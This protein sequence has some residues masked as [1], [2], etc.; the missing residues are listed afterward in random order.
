MAP[1]WPLAA[2]LLCAVPLA[3]QQENR[4][5]D[6]TTREDMEWANLWW[7]HA[8]DTKL[9]RVLLIGDSITNGY[10][11]KVRDLLRGRAN[12]DLL[13][14]SAS[15]C[16]PALIAQVKLAVGD[17]KHAIIHFNNGLHGFH[18]DEA[19]YEAGLRRL[20]DTLKQLE[21]QAKLIWAMSTPI[22]L[23]NDVGKLDP[24]NEVV[25]KRNEIAA[26]VM[27]ELGIPVDDLYSLVAGKAEYRVSGDGY[28]YNDQGRTVEAD[29][30]AK[31]VGEAL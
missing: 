22:V 26:R 3:A 9:P 6:N 12:V 5:L 24:K 17:Y 1:I 28:H 30:V 25:L 18:L 31:V 20:V 15:I 4:T 23:G 13:A 16:D 10:H 7:E 21:P 2:C 27:R 8:P 19:H 11:G 14:T 29:A